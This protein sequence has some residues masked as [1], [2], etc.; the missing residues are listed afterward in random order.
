MSM[1]ER[2][3]AQGGT[4]AP[5]CWD[6]R[7][8]GLDAAF[9]G[10][11]S[12]TALSAIQ[13]TDKQ[14]DRRF[15]GWELYRTVIAGDSIFWRGLEAYAILMARAVT[16]ST[17]RTGHP[18][19]AMR[20]RRNAWIAQA[21]RDALFI[22]VTGKPPVGINERSASLGVSNGV[23]Q[24]VRDAVAGGMCIGLETYRAMLFVNYWRVRQIGG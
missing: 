1:D 4:E 18:T 13:W 5:G 16:R 10:R 24:R 12:D 8:P 23:Y 14:F 19:V 6:I 21:G 20:A 11:L 2:T 15:P 3:E 7:G 17:R 9:S 22:A